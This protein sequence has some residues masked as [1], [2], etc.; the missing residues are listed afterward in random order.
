MKCD[1]CNKPIICFK[2]QDGNFCSVYCAEIFYLIKTRTSRSIEIPL[3][4]EKINRIKQN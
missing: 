3:S 4:K 2:T 1:S